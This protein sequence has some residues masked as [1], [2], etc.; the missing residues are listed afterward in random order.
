MLKHI[1]L[2]MMLTLVNCTPIEVTFRSM[3]G[4]SVVQSRLDPSMPGYESVMT[5]I[6]DS[7]DATLGYKGPAWQALKQLCPQCNDPLIKYS[8]VPK[9]NKDEALEVTVVSLK[10]PKV[11]IYIFGRYYTV[12][13]DQ[14]ILDEWQERKEDGVIELSREDM[15][16]KLVQILEA[17]RVSDSDKYVT[18]VRIRGARDEDA[19]VVDDHRTGWASSEAANRPKPKV[20]DFNVIKETGCVHIEH[21][22]WIDFYL[23]TL[24]PNEEGICL[25][26]K[27]DTTQNTPKWVKEVTNMLIHYLG[28]FSFKVIIQDIILSILSNIPDDLQYR[29]SINGRG[30]EILFKNPD[31]TKCS[32]FID[33][34]Y[35]WDHKYQFHP[36]NS[37]AEFMPDANESRDSLKTLLMNLFVHNVPIESIMRVERID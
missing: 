6:T 24:A 19:F 1:L 9:I 33:E 20:A 11:G 16:T 37:E 32:I 15:P 12:A 4:E 5:E 13:L 8:F 31:D 14:E 17:Y 10:K 22:G 25:I 18:S 36:N 34:I 27:I 30:L 3:S 7:Q 21:D 35:S 28:D 2:L 29:T 23:A 26:L